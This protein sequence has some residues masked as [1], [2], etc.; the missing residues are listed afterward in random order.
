MVKQQARPQRRLAPDPMNYSAH[1]S[2]DNHVH[3]QLRPSLP[4]LLS[5]HPP[6]QKPVTRRKLHLRFVGE[7]RVGE[8]T[9]ARW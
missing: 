9:L 7:P 5:I 6:L 1:P 3:R 2:R 4:L 8:A